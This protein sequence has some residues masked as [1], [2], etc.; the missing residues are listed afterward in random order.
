MS[1]DLRSDTFTKPCDAMRDAMAHAEVGDDVFGEDPTVNRLQEVVAEMLGKEEGL[2]V[3]S[4]TMANQT[5]INAHTQPGDEVILE[6]TSHIFYYEAGAPALLSGVQLRTL[7]GNAGILTA[8]EIS[9]AIRPE[10]VHFPP[11]RLIC[12]EN[13]HNSAGGTIYPLDEIRRIRAL[14]DEHGLRMHLDGA[15]LWNAS[16]ASGIPLK[17][18]ASPFDSVSVCFSKGLGAPVGSMIAGDA[19]FIRRAHRYRKMYGGGMRQAGIIAA[20][21]LYAVENNVGRLEEDHRNARKLAEAAARLP[22]ISI[23]LDT[24]QTNIV[25]MEV[26]G[27]RCTAQAAEDRLREKGVLVLALGPHRLRAVTHLEVT[28][29][30]IDRAIRVFEETFQG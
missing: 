30:D 4:G 27:A 25:Y 8:E 24:V 2:F 3:A 13:T 14:A 11:T 18:Y 16:V 28:E 10:N 12:L 9:H 7:P 17:E 6:G 20:G 1:V 21:A 23:D 22:G 15:R 19:A 29:V 5:A 26:D